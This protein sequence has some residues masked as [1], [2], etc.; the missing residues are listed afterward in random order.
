[1]SDAIDLASGRYLNE[2]AIR[3]QALR[4][5]RDCRNGKFTRVGSDF[6][7]EVK[8]D[9]EALLRDLRGKAQTLHPPIMFG[10][11]SFVTGELMDKSRDILNELIG[12]MIQNKVQKQP[13]CGCTLGR[14]R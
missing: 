12:R 7:D 11:D 10:D 3:E 5:S 2:T 8:A 13:S 6:V 4:C 1:M 14:T 9:V